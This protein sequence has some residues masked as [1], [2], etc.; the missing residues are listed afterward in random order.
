MSKPSKRPAY[1]S[2]FRLRSMRVPLLEYD[3]YKFHRTI[4]VAAKDG[5]T[6]DIACKD[7]ETVLIA[8]DW[9]KYACMQKGKQGGYIGRGMSKWAFQVSRPL[10]YFKINNRT[11]MVGPCR[12]DRLC[13]LPFTTLVY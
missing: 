5:G 2:M 4:C 12:S 8:K 13:C 6:R 7:T 1:V 3:A 11:N 9:F 10:C